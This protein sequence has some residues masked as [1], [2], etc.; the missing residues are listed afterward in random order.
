MIKIPKSQTA[1][2]RTCDYAKVDIKTL[3]QSS[4][5][6]IM[7]VYNGLEFFKRM[8]TAAAMDH[9]Y[10]KIQ[11]LREFHADFITGFKEHSWWDKHKKLSRHH[12][13]ED[14]GIPEDV[15]LVDVLEMIVD[16]V[17]AGM[18]RS[19]SVYPLEIKIDVLIK[20][21]QNTVELLKKNVEISN[22]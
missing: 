1:D 14:A 3:R 2:T 11:N 19:G 5:Q 8:I 10:D 18:A 17:M 7:D 12:L 15:N 20:A 9:D 16:C 22:E 13:L 4:Y 6:H 21:F